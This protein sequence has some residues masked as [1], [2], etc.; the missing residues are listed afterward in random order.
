MRAAWYSRFGDA[1][2]VLETGEIE[3]PEVGAGALVLQLGAYGTAETAERVLAQ[4]R[5]KGFSAAFVL[6]PGDA[7][8][9]H[10]VQVGPFTS[11]DEAVRV[12]SQ[13]QAAD[14]EAIIVR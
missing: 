14:F 3:A 10:R 13:L 7:S 1:A 4:A 2:E 6:R 9:Y 12:R 5:E 11:E 8:E